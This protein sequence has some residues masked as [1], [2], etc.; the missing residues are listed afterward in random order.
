MAWTID[1]INESIV[2]VGKPKHGPL[3]ELGREIY[4]EISRRIKLNENV[5]L[6]DIAAKLAQG[7]KE[8]P[9]KH[10]GF[11]DCADRYA[12]IL[13][14]YHPENTSSPDELRTRPIERIIDGPHYLLVVRNELI[15]FTGQVD[16]SIYVRDHHCTHDGGKFNSQILITQLGDPGQFAMCRKPGKVDP[17]HNVADKHCGA[18]GRTGY[19]V[20]FKK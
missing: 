19:L 15:P 3:F 9:S 17:F 11:D 18:M 6:G 13:T 10:P 12:D 20:E 8:L 14:A 4:D 2:R 16:A 5:N 7:F 1:E